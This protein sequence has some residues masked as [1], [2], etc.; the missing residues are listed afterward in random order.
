METADSPPSP[1]ARPMLSI[2]PTEHPPRQ[3]YKIM[4][5]IIVP[6]PIALVSTVDRDGA[7]NVAPFSF[8]CGVGSNPPTVL[9][10]PALRASPG[11]DPTRRKD[12]LRNVEET[13]EFVVDVV[14]DG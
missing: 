7:A 1:A 3:I 8:F 14:S 4:T 10:C 13:G 2:D 9:F 6:R 12:T 11:T 5:G